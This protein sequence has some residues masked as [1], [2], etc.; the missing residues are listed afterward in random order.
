MPSPFKLTQIYQALTAKNPL[1]K[2]KLKLGTSEIPIPPKRQD[3]LDTEVINRFSKANP[4]VDTTEFTPFLK[5]SDVK[6]PDEAMVQDAVSKPI[7][8]LDPEKD[9]FKKISNVLGAYKK[10]RRGEKN[11]KLNFNKFFELYSTENFA[12]GGRAGYEDGGM[13]VQ[14]N[15]DGSRPGYKGE[16]KLITIKQ[17]AELDLPYSESTLSNVFSST[18]RNKN[19]KKLFKD[20][21]IKVVSKGPK[22]TLLFDI[23]SAK[24]IDNLWQDSI[25]L[26]E[27]GKATVPD[28][29][30]NP[31]KNEV[32]KVFN[33]FKK[34][35]TPFT[36]SDIYYKVV[37]NVGDN[38][39]I[40][41]PKKLK[42]DTRVPGESIKVALGK[43]NSEFLL[44]GNIARIE[45]TTTNR[46]KM[47][48][49]LLKGETDV[50]SL[51]KNL[52]INK[53]D[54]Y[55]E[56]NKLFDDSYRYNSNIVRK[57]GAGSGYGYLKDYSQSDFNTVLKNLR[58]SGFEKLDERSARA[59]IYDAYKDSP[60]KFDA[61]LKKLSEY[62]KINT[63][64]RNTFG[65]GFQL[66][67]TLSFKALKDLGNTTA[68]NLI[69]F[70]P[71]PENINK[72]KVTFDRS[73]NNIIT[74]LR[75][76]NIS[77]NIS[78]NLLEKKKLIEDI[79]TKTNI[80]S[81][82]VD[83]SG[84]KILSFGSQPFLKSDIPS[85]M[86]KNVDVQNRLVDVLKDYSDE[87]LK[88]ITQK[89]G[90]ESLKNLEKIPKKEINAIKSLIASLGP[91]TCSVFS[92]KKATLK[93]DG[94][95][96]GLATGTPNLDECYDAATAA[97]NS[98]KVPV[99]KADDF[100]KLLKRVG[101][102]GRGIM[103]FGIIPEAMYVAADSLVRLGMG[104][105]FKEAGLLASD[106]LL[107]GDQAKASEMSKVKRFFG[108]E[109]GEL[110]G[111]VIDYKNQLAKIQ[112]LEGQ[113]SNLDN[114][115]DAGEFDYIGDLS[116]ESNTKKN[117]L[118]Q[119]KNDLDNKFKISEAE[120]L[121]A[122]SK[123]DDAYD[124]S[125]ATSFLSNLKR[126][127]RDSSDNLSDVET[128]AAPE[129]TQMQLNLDMLPAVPKDFM[130]A[131]DDALRN[132]VRAES[133]R[134]GEKLNPQLY[135]DEKE[136]LKK[137]FMTKGPGVYGKE[138]VYG[139]QGTFGGEPVDMTNYQ[140][141]NRFGSGFQQRPVLYPQGRNPLGLA[142]GGIASL[143]KTIP[144]ESGPT[145][146]GLPYVYNNVKKI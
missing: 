94:G 87:D 66:D 9:S 17:L 47:F 123:Q 37:E 4:R 115:S 137:E 129:K 18:D 58:N 1:L 19:L 24:Q 91:G 107:P 89:K 93:A 133:V 71:L 10:Y 57:T 45:K 36:T 124:A 38:K 112:S 135:I 122:E 96:I 141:S 2:K 118:S 121:Y 62:N 22:N 63:E 105:T 13:L 119:A 132:Y 142:S 48:D 40:F 83:A 30:R 31:F 23:P 109:T 35:N 127:Y 86:L 32:L 26:I 72:M 75:E 33:E 81:F 67:H 29:M 7:I 15:D 136:K 11:P 103:K 68:E 56:A 14:P 70:N 139:T 50:T 125:A 54:V 116:G 90:F 126:K 25:K 92:G 97:I 106:Y 78:K 6:K 41:I 5:Q 21:N 108:D 8:T 44:D 28:K 61:A 84:K 49:L 110:V 77:P 144:P 64:L 102:I 51:A 143:T 145:P 111:R 76:G 74:Q 53:K 59:L 146:Q 114:L 131:T 27:S 3:V 95:R 60:K 100:T 98:G 20:N 130:M 82:K 128:L 16:K 113:V 43:E 34:T 138:Q 117:L 39:R 104:N 140:P 99:D 85:Q 88:K 73:Y 46:K 69:R 65:K 42:G 80:G 52:G 120:Q 55:A 101:T 134:S 12:E 79:S